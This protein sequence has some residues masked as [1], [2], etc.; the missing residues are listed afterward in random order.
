MTI[1]KCIPV[2]FDVPQIFDLLSP[3][4][5]EKNICLELYDIPGLDDNGTKNVYFKWVENN[6]NLFDIV[7]FVTSIETAINSSCELEILQLLL[8][9]I[10]THKQ[11]YNRDIKLITVINKC[12]NMMVNEGV[13]DKNDPDDENHEMFE[14]VSNILKTE[15]S[16]YPEISVAEPL[17]L[18]AE[19]AFIYRT[20]FVTPDDEFPDIDNKHINKMGINEYG[21]NK[22][23]REMEKDSDK[24]RKK[25]IEDLHIKKNYMEHMQ[26][27]GFYKFRSVLNETIENNLSI[28]LRQR[29][30]YEIMDHPVFNDDN[31]DTYFEFV[32][33]IKTREQQINRS[34]HYLMKVLKILLKY[35]TMPSLFTWIK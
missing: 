19:D 5:R 2:A 15:S 13:L 35:C 11:K 23:N 6:F 1:D 22:W 33:N 26:T 32:K 24:Y 28:F 4:N 7:I 31:I 34:T 27:S 3:K 21:K 20:T 16:K 25:L 17:C 30:N 9:N 29:M 8:K 10:M 18:S 12:D 14:Q